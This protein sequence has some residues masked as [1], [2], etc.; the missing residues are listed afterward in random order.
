[1]SCKSLEPFIALRRLFEVP[2]RFVIAQRFPERLP[3]AEAALERYFASTATRA[4]PVSDLAA[5][6]LDCGR[7]WS[8]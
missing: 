2:W 4:C 6:R 8:W 3:E 7:G 1:M 5:V